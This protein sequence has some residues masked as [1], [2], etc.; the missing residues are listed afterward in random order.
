MYTVTKKISWLL[1]VL[2]VI[3]LFLSPIG[4]DNAEAKGSLAA[5]D[6]VKNI[7]V[8]ETNADG[9]EILISRLNVSDMLTYLNAH[10]T[11]IGK[12]HNYALLDNY[13][14][15]VHQEAQGF[16][17]PQLL[18]YAKTKSNIS[19]INDWGLTFSGSDSISFWEIDGAAFDSAD[20]YT[21][22]SL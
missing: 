12:V 14:A 21:Y 17:V 7:L 19:N 2:M 13:V 9:E 16:T 5:G 3:G 18:D 1:V 20:T 15:S 4:S 8:Y 22:D 10:E 11:E 6:T